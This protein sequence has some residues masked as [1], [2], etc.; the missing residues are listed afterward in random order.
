MVLSDVQ[1]GGV[2][3]DVGELGVVEPALPEGRHHLVQA[4][5]DAADLGLGDPGLAPSAPTSSSTARVET[6][7][8]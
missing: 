2:Q 8:T 1:V 5:A 3:P 7:W 4:L 6:P